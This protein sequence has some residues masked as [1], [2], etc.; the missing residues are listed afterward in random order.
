M[1]KNRHAIKDWKQGNL[2]ELSHWLDKFDLKDILK[3]GRQLPYII[4][5][6]ADDKQLCFEMVLGLVFAEYYRASCLLL[7]SD[8]F[9]KDRDSSYN[10]YLSSLETIVKF[11]E[12][13]YFE[14]MFTMEA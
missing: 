5:L 1:F 11:I 4:E 6:E 12:F 14:L 10:A 3:Y 13:L 7:R 8:E 9:N 2:R